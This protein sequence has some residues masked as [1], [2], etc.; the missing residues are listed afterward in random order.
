MFNRSD[1]KV[2]NFTSFCTIASTIGKSGASVP[3]DAKNYAVRRIASTNRDV[4]VSEL[5]WYPPDDYQPIRGVSAYLVRM[6]APAPE[7]AEGKLLEMIQGWKSSRD[8]GLTRDMARC[9]IDRRLVPT[10]VYPNLLSLA[11]IEKN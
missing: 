11:T 2:R 7:S 9:L 5:E 1:T 10:G 8:V 4:R 3:T 6:D